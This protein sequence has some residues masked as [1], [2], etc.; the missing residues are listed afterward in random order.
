MKDFYLNGVRTGGWVI[1]GVPQNTEHGR[2]YAGNIRLL[3][4]AEHPDHGNSGSSDRISIDFIS[5]YLVGELVK[6]IE[7]SICSLKTRSQI[8]SSIS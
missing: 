3:V 5:V 1:R 7:K 8:R 6:P 2:V 4:T